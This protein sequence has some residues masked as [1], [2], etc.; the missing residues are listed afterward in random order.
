MEAMERKGVIWP[1]IIAEKFFHRSPDIVEPTTPVVETTPPEQVDASKPIDEPHQPIPEV[2]VA[3]PS[4]P[5]KKPFWKRT[6]TYVAGAILSAFALVAGIF[7]PQIRNNRSQKE[8]I[9]EAAQ[10][11]IVK[12]GDQEKPPAATLEPNFDLGVSP[13]ELSAERLKEGIRATANDLREETKNAL[14]AL[15]VGLLKPIRDHIAQISTQEKTLE[16]PLQSDIATIRRGEGVSHALKR[17]L[18]QKRDEELQANKDK[19][20]DE[21]TETW[22]LTDTEITTAALRAIPTF[23]LPRL[24]HINEQWNFTFDT[25]TKQFTDVR[26]FDKKFV[27]LQ[28]EKYAAQPEA[29]IQTPPER[30]S[31]NLGNRTIT[32]GETVEYLPLMAQPGRFTITRI[33][34]DGKKIFIKNALVGE[35]PSIP[36]SLEN[37]QMR[38]PEKGNKTYVIDGLWFE[39]LHGG[40]TNIRFT[41]LSGKGV[42]EAIATLILHED[43]QDDQTKM[44]VALEAAHHIV[45]EAN[46]DKHILDTYDVTK[47]VSEIPNIVV[48]TDSVVVKKVRGQRVIESGHFSRGKTTKIPLE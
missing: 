38:S 16:N 34:P 26:K 29:E 40:A 18:E 44:K 23:E 11:V 36:V 22:Q 33:S 45:S 5:V 10:P 46:K 48:S 21:R 13:A 37:F 19:K 39:E 12:V 32:V 14:S 2:T 8:S 42:I 35:I 30:T 47:E 27:A 28:T 6:S 1:K 3:A 4:A 17:M 15:D 41:T 9:E 24:T 7:V 20:P 31:V 25:Q 43:F